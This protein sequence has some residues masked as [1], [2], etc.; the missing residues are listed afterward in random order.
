M[1]TDFLIG[2]IRASR[3]LH[4]AVQTELEEILYRAE[5]VEPIVYK[6]DDSDWMDAFCGKCQEHLYRALP[7]MDTGEY[8]DKTKYC[9]ECGRPVDWT[10]NAERS[11]T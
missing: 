1:T 2:A 3:D 7:L 10:R 9:F 4:P 5:P 11:N 6:E 8:P